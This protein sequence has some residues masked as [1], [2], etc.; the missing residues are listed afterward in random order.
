MKLALRILTGLGVY[1]LWVHGLFSGV[2]YIFLMSEA[3]PETFFERLAV[4]VLAMLW[5][6]MYIIGVVAHLSGVL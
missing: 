6:L 1:L 4:L 2:F 5:P 3:S